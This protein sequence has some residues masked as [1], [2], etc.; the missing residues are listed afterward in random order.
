[1]ATNGSSGFR[2]RFPSQRLYIQCKPMKK[3]VTSA[4][5]ALSTSALAQKIEVSL[6][7][8]AQHGHLIVVFAKDDKSEPRMQ[9][10][11]QYQSAQGFGVDVGIDGIP[12][13][14][15]VTADAK[16][17]GYPLRSLTDIPAGDYF[18]Q[19]VFNV[20]EQFHLAN[21][22]SPWLPPD[23]G[24][25]QKWN[26]KPGNVYSKPVKVHFDG[27]A[28]TT[29]KLTLDQTI[30]EIKGSKQDP[31]VIAKDPA[32]SKWLK[33]MRFKSEKLSKFWGRDMYLGAWVLL[34]EGFDEHPDAHYPLVVWQGHFSAGMQPAFTAVAG[35][36]GRRGD[37]GYRFFQDWTTGRLPRAIVLY[38]QNANPYYDD[39]YDVDSANVGP[40]GSAIND[41][42]IPAVEAKYR[43][44]G[45]G[46]A[47]ATAGGSTGGW[48]AI[49]TQVFYP[50]G[51]N[52]TW[53]ACPDPVDFHAYQN[54][55]LYDDPNAFFRHGD[56]G[57]VPV[58]TDRKPDGSILANT[59]DEFAFE[60]VLGTHGRSTEQWGIWQAVFS[61]QGPDG[62][63][64]DVLDPITGEIH[65]DVVQYWREHYDINAIL[66][67]DWS[68][69]GPKVE[70]KMHIA[71]GDG[72]TYFLNNA[73][74]LLDNQL[75]LTRNPRSDA[76][77][78]YGP[79]MPHCYTGGPSEYTMQQNNANWIQRLL[80]L[81][82]EHMKQTA[83]VGADVKSWVY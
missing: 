67:R 35:G 47:R 13:T 51:Y 44:I 1:M 82:T 25:G 79:G 80:P 32:T 7:D 21:G 14:K 83:P 28:N 66:K 65:K 64:V 4:L 19:G 72:D 6:P 5:F 71:V 40:Y 33:Y 3:I 56:F 39:S 59:G 58:P 62:Y 46:W 12:S 8:A 11:E 78:Q 27:K 23:K 73:V 45:A 49:A 60:Y 69:L 15:T 70:G 50:D 76:E 37:S 29:I 34:P 42:L 17:L 48:E 61:P 52:G 22:K 74:H 9:M 53:G 57:S 10:Q 30:P 24:E 55:N 26:R 2:A 54:I 18:V 43:G 81:M 20:Y 63:P 38:V 16:T 75:K 36:G 77:F 31:E 41:E 68:T